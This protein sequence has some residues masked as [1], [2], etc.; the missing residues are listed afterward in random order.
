METMR[1]IGQHVRRQRARSSPCAIGDREHQHDDLT[2]PML[3]QITTTHPADHSETRSAWR[4]RGE[5]R[6]RIRKLTLGFGITLMVPAA[7][8]SAGVLFW[9]SPGQPQYTT[10]K[11]NRDHKTKQYKREATHFHHSHLPPSVQFGRTSRS[12]RICEKNHRIQHH[13]LNN[14]LIRIK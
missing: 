5:R 12:P 2:G 10:A 6:S 14:T 13:I 3:A 11:E 4:W 8:T 7:D 1:F 9:S